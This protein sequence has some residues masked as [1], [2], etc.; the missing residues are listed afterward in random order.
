MKKNIILIISI[1]LCIIIL[2]VFSIFYLKEYF[3]Y[4][5]ILAVIDDAKMQ[6]SDINNIKVEIQPIEK[7]S[8]DAIYVIKDGIQCS[9]DDRNYNEEHNISY[10]IFDSN[11]KE[12]YRIEEKR[13][14]IQTVKDEEL[15]IFN[16]LRGLKIPQISLFNTYDY[17]LKNDRFN[18]I[19]CYKITINKNEEVLYEYWIS[20]ENGLLMKEYEKQLTSDLN[21][22]QDEVIFEWNYNY[23]FDIVTDE[24][25]KEIN[26]ENYLDYQIV[27]N[28]LKNT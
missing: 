5:K 27:D 18:D 3:T 11:K 26:S 14:A 22:N 12:E 19:E 25:V 21:G 7:S 28:R 2:C 24:Q 20:K 13:I 23:T 1:V 10:T 9:T 16:L 17:E 6:V 15:F 4:K 8:N